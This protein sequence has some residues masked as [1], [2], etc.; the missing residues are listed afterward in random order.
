MIW[1]N[2]ISGT[3]WSGTYHEALLAS[4]WVMYTVLA[5]VRFGASQGSRQAAVSAVAGFVFLL[6]A[7]VGVELLV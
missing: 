4:A 6:F 3:F 7:V 5:A 1:V 2:S